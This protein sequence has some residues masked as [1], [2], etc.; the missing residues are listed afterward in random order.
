MADGRTGTAGAPRLLW[1]S[2]ACVATGFARVTHAALGQLVALGWDAHVLGLGY[3]GDPHDHPYPVHPASRTGDVWGLDRVARLAALVRPDV[4]VVQHD[5]WVVPDYARALRRLPVP[6]VGWMPVD[7][8]NCRGAKLD[9]LALS[10]FYTEFGAAEA[11]AGGLTGRSAVVGL[12][13]DTG[14]FAPMDRALARGMALPD[15]PAGA[16]VVGV[17][18]RNQPRKRLDLALSFFADW[19]RRTGDDAWLLMHTTS[20]DKGWDLRQLADHLGVRDRLLLHEEAP[21]AG[22]PEDLLRAAYCACDFHVTATQG[23]GFGLTTLEGMACGI[24]QVVP[25]WS[26]L[27]EWVSRGAVRVPVAETLATAGGANMLG[28]VADRAAFVNAMRV[29]H[30][31]SGYRARLGAEALALAREPRFRWEWIGRRLDRLLRGVVAGVADDDTAGNYAP[32][33]VAVPREAAGAAW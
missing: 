31:E 22:V 7:G 23:E 33:V 24:A 11:R 19:R 25:A 8:R 17:F 6:V 12:G 32:A 14:A 3:R 27:G 13:V 4:V 29:L 2:D 10:I 18:A 26:A 5:P 28:G 9:P 21:G 30:T 1:V 20:S 15:L 16:R